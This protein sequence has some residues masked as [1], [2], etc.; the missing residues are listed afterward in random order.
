MMFYKNLSLIVLLSVLSAPAFAVDY[1]IDAAKSKIGFSGEQAGAKFEGVFQKWDAKI[2]FDPAALDKSTIDVTIMPESAK[3][4]TPMYD[5]TL[6]QKDWF[7]VKDFPK[8]TFKSTKITAG[9]DGDYIAEGD[10]TI[11]GITKPASFTFK[12]DDV[13]K[14][15]VHATGQLAVNRL[16][17]AIGAESD[18]KAEWVSKDIP[19]ALDIYAAKTN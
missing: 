18:G 8:A 5:A 12:I 10:L 16:D 3:T 19:I 6:P 17:Y 7:N 14:S 13:T 2:F 11:R 9:K 4:G 15:E 1:A